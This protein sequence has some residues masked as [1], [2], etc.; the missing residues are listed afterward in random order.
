MSASFSVIITT[1]LASNYKNIKKT[2]KASNKRV[3]TMLS[4]KALNSSGFQWFQGQFRQVR[5]GGQ[6]NQTIPL[7]PTK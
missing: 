5:L 4:Q 2:F 7:N 6:F 3:T 1:C